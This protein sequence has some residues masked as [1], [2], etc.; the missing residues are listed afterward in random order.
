MRKS[1]DM[2]RPVIWYRDQTLYLF[3]DEGIFEA[4]PSFKPSHFTSFVW[5][6]VDS[7]EARDGVPPQLVPQGTH[8]YVIYVT[9]PRTERWSRLH[10]TTRDSLVIM[11]P[12]TRQ[13]IFK[14]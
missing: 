8:L 7:D 4:P 9:S 11:N 13:E 1:L 2:K 10:K 3:V 12:W 6:F 14:A 5:T